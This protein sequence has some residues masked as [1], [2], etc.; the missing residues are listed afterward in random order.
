ML[1]VP[2]PFLESDLTPARYARCPLSIFGEGMENRR[3]GRGEVSRMAEWIEPE[4]GRMLA[5]LLQYGKLL[6]ELMR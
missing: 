6:I 1:A 2:S 4:S 5:V 3:F